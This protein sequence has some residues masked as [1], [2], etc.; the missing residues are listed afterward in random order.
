MTVAG[1]LKMGVVG[2][3]VSLS[4][5]QPT[6]YN[7]PAPKGI[8]EQQGRDLR[9]EWPAKQKNVYEDPKVHYSSE[10]LPIAVGIGAG[11]FAAGAAKYL[12]DKYCRGSASKSEGQGVLSL[13]DTERGLEALPSD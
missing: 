7:G 2:A 10:G 3:A 8:Q 1:I 5:G 11:L 4:G 6:S 13:A 9:R 12:C